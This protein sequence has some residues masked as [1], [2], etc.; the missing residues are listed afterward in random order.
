MVKGVIDYSPAVDVD[1]VTVHFQVTGDTGP[2]PGNGHYVNGNGA[3]AAVG[4][5]MLLL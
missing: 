4:G 2:R 5:R 1:D 3:E